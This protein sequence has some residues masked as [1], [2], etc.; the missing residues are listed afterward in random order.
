M[1]FSIFLVSRDRE[2]FGPTL[3]APVRHSTLCGV[4]L[5]RSLS[6]NNECFTAAHVRDHNAAMICFVQKCNWLC[7]NVG[8]QVFGNRERKI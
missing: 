7:C 5:E 1:I 4:L 8:C 2:S 6:W 3:T